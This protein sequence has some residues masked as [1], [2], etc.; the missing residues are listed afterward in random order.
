MASSPLAWRLQPL[1]AMARWPADAPLAAFI[2][3]DQGDWSR[4][5]VL[6]LPGTWRTLPSN[7]ERAEAL[8]WLRGLAHTPQPRGGEARMPGDG[9]WILQCGY[10]LGAALEPATRAGAREA[11]PWPLAQAAP[12]LAA[13][14]HDA[15]SG[16]WFRVGGE[17]A[18]WARIEQAME[19][20]APSSRFSIDR[21]HPV[22]D[23]QAY[24]ALVARTVQLIHAGDLFQ[25]NVARLWKAVGRGSP[26]AFALAATV[27]YTHLTLPT[28]A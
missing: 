26:R 13:A 17:H 16:R 18:D 8:A 25:A 19:V 15:G 21:P 4:W 28:K 1:Q 24:A 12:I 5:S 27:S 2:S 6:A 10:E 3:G 20:A 9:G 23:D 7:A 11:S 22:S 14:V